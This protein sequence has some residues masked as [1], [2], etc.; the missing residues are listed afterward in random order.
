[1]FMVKGR[2]LAIDYGETRIGLA[3][4]DPM[5]VIAAGLTT[6]IVKNEND[7][8]KQLTVIIR[9]QDV[10]QI[11]LGLP[12]DTQGHL[13]A[14]AMKIKS[15]ADVLKKETDILVD[16]CD[17]RFS[18]VTAKKMLLESEPKK[19]RRGKEKIDT[20]AA[21]VILRHYMDSQR[22]SSV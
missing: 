22:Q 18:S 1:M 13:S 14:K 8:I 3:L 16:Y 4:S 6:L 9:E 5:R 11:V 21:V 17:E 2:I 7:A 19:K 15:F 10:V 20:L 12:Y